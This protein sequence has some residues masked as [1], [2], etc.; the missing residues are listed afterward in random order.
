MQKGLHLWNG[1]NEFNGEA[2]DATGYLSTI[3]LLDVLNILLKLT[4][5]WRVLELCI[6]A[7]KEVQKNCMSAWEEQI[8]KVFHGPRE[9][10]GIQKL[11]GINEVCWFN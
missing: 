8:W 5:R 6:S 1:E 10:Q 9:W 7:E 11:Q 4:F 2:G 3:L